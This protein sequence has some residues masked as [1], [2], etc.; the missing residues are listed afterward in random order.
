MSKRS[1]ACAYEMIVRR[2]TRPSRGS[3][4]QSR[5]RSGNDPLGKDVGPGTSV[6]DDAGDERLP[7]P[8]PQSYK[9]TSVIGRRG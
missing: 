3:G 2:I 1:A 7:K 4:P 6:E 8:I 5:D 9:V